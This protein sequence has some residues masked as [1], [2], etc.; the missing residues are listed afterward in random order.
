M[1]R[2]RQIFEGRAKILFEGPEPGTLVQY[3]K[4][5][6]VAGPQDVS[7]IVTGKGVLNNRISEF[8]LTRLSEIGIPTY[9]VRRMNMREQ[10]VREVE[11]IPLEVIVRNCAAGRF[12]QRFNMPEGA[13]LPR[14][15]VEFFYK[16]NGG[17]A[18]LVSEEHMTAFGWATPPDIDEMVALSLRINDF[19]TGIFTGI[20]MKLIDV[21]LEFGRLWEDDQPRVVLADEICPESCTAWDLQVGRRL[22]REG[23]ARDFGEVAEQYQEFARRLGLLADVGGE[24]GADEERSS[25]IEMTQ[26]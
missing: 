13:P 7:G 3:F 16:L 1:P 6:V 12:A 17:E 22:Y 8:F 25:V 15:I 24:M 14:S 20:G 9:F 19:L 18:P 4:D 26:P 11:M 21:K 2:R 23:R 10:V 5:D